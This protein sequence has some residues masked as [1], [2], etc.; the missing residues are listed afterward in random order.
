[1]QSSLPRT[2]DQFRALQHRIEATQPLAQQARMQSD[3]LS[4]Q[5]EALRRRLEVTTTKLQAL[6][7]EKGRIDAELARLIPEE[8][9]LAQNFTADR[10][11]VSRL[12][13]VLE[14]M[15]SDPPPVIALHADDAL[16]AVRGAMLLGAAVPRLYH[17]ASA[18]ADQLR[19]LKTERAELDRRSKD[20]LRVAAA[21]SATRIALDQLLVTKS[22]AAQQ[23]RDRYDTLQARLLGAAQSAGDL[24]ALLARVAALR[25]PATER[26]IVDVAPL[27]G[28]GDAPGPPVTVQP[29][30]GVASKD[31]SGTGREPAVEMQTAPAATVVAPGDAAVLYAGPYRLSRN[32]LILE[33]R[34]GYDLVLAGLDRIDVRPGDEVLAGE[35]VGA[36]PR[37]G[38]RLYFEVRQNGKAVDP[39]AWMKI[40]PRKAKRS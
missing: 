36:M 24:Q 8:R 38:S 40:D 26:G 14:T 6:E 15:Q 2:A 19:R 3:T 35:P 31:P 37:A 11:R 33:T 4:A 16:A 29:V 23:A 32:V 17:A 20:D 12:L 1:M 22:E 5:T 9:R 21:L 39:A 27:H 30:I 34:G 18:L 7:D 10:A 13:A 25:Q 28:P